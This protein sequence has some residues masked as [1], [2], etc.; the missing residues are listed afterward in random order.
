MEGLNDHSCGLC[1]SP[2]CLS[3]LMQRSGDC[4]FENMAFGWNIEAMKEAMDAV[5]GRSRSAS[6]VHEVT[7]C[8]EFTRYTIEGILPDPMDPGHNGVF[9]PFALGECFKAS[10]FSEKKW[11]DPL[12]YGMAIIE[13]DIRV[14]I[15]GRGKVIVR[16]AR[17]K[18]EAKA[19]YSEVSD[20]MRPSLLCGLG[21][22][23]VAEALL[24]ISRG[25]FVPH[26]GCIDAMMQ[27]PGEDLVPALSLERTMS[28][29]EAKRMED[30]GPLS[31]RVREVLSGDPIDES[32]SG[33]GETMGSVLGRWSQQEI[34]GYGSREEA[35]ACRSHSLVLV[36]G[37]WGLSKLVAS[38]E[39]EEADRI[40]G[41]TREILDS[42]TERT[43]SLQDILHRV[44][45]G[46][47]WLRYL[48]RYL[49]NVEL[50][51]IV[52]SD[53]TEAH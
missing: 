32:R 5:V 13:D 24:S 16:R 33:I 28:I 50:R 46:D 4:P 52:K 21:G 22:H 1:D 17:T 39:G 41:M 29:F 12:S 25:S 51:A 30:A 38:F 44:S 19:L 47:P 10:R 45:S 26:A 40:A 11:S 49:Y 35:L 15:Q 34:D 2:N 14:H 37:L 3:H 48:W 42:V 43:I 6:S 18:Q 53:G 23:T 27:W 8:S 20:L 7:P 31:C 9:H 36:S